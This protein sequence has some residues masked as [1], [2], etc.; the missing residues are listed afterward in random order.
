MAVAVGNRVW[1]GKYAGTEIRLDG[2]DL[3]VLR[4]SDILGVFES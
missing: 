1:F 4:E 3:L 2:E